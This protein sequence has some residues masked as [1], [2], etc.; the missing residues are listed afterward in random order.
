MPAQKHFNPYY[1]PEEVGLSV[2]GEVD[3]AG[4]YE[5]NTIVAWTDGSKLYWAHDSGCSCPTPFEDSEVT[6]E[7]KSN[8]EELKESGLQSFIDEVMEMD[9]PLRERQEFIDKVKKVLRGK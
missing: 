7:D 1:S 6:M 4:S 3:D 2:I 5:F 8:I 9:L